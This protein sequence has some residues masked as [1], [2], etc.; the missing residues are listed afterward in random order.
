MDSKVSRHMSSVLSAKV[1]RNSSKVEQLWHTL[2]I[3]NVHMP[4]FGFK[5]H[6]YFN[7]RNKITEKS[8]VLVIPIFLHGTI[9]LHDL[10]LLLS[11]QFG[12]L[13]SKLGWF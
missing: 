11:D 5:I 6:S 9:N 8:T 7:L 12:H 1:K 10:I 3:G 13:H 4:T 2:D